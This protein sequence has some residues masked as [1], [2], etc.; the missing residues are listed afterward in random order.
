MPSPRPGAPCVLL[1]LA[2]VAACQ[3]G[4][5]P[6]VE[7]AP[8]P[9]PRAEPVHAAIAALEAGDLARARAT[10]DALIRT[11][12]LA[13]ARA[14]LAGAP[15]EALV[16]IDECLALAPDDVELQ[17]LKADASLRLAET[18]I[19][20]G[21]GH[22]GLIEG[23]LL[24]AFE[25]YTR[26]GRSPHALFGASRAAF[27]QGR[28]DEAIALARAGFDAAGRTELELGDLARRPE[29]I[30]AEE[31]LVAEAAARAEGRAEADELRREAEDALMRLLGRVSDDPWTWTWLASLQEGDGRLADAR[32]SLE[33]GLKR[34]PE[35]AGMLGQLARVTATL[36]GPGEAV[37]ALEAFAAAHPTL[38][39]AR[40]QLSVAR[41]EAEL[42]RYQETQR[43]LAPDAF[44][45]LE[46]E[47]RVLRTET[48]E[49]TSSAYGYEAVCRL[50]RGWCAFHAGELE[51]AHDEFLAMNA[52]FERAIE[53][54][55]PG[56]MESGIQGLF[57]VADTYF[58]REDLEAA[59]AI[60]ERLHELQPEDVSWANNAGF[61]LRDAADVLATEARELCAVA[62][63]IETH[64]E[65]LAER[66]AKI[67]LRAAPG[68][69][70]ERAEFR[71]AADERATRALALME[72][73]F[74]AYEAAAALAPEDV[75]IVNDA[76]LVLVYYLHRDLERAERWL[77][78]CVE[79][80]GPQLEA[81][82]AALAVEAVPERA[83]QLESE[84][85]LLQEAWA[86]AHQNL[87]VLFWLHHRDGPSAGAWL[88]KAVAIDPE[89]QSRIAVRNMLLPQT[90]GE[91]P[92]EPGDDWDLLGWG[93]PCP[94]P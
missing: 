16:S 66:R 87:G 74:S 53:W 86:D 17:L 63:G 9:E 21:G 61:N 33:L 82:R 70:E 18:K 11:R 1:P 91:V 52:L 22:A 67:G 44:A 3:G 38:P 73:S 93:R 36:A 19:A 55:Y 23:S 90:R 26:A 76:A 43:V 6:A 92:P 75:R 25:Y 83:A 2:L 30:L 35:D 89:R 34:V 68:S 80:G 58:V 32:R 46:D 27:L 37:R 4:P 5:A 71:A 10:L 40:W 88:E 78:R 77:L 12:Q 69:N 54:A 65:L 72:R 81:K 20:S 28:T 13:E 49:Y 15:D 94:E 64:P 85:D 59:G 8:V 56:V 29:R 7:P 41:F 57:F 42:A 79:L 14:K 48:P 51:R 62:R 45:R 50:A 84:L 39:A 31:L 47:F 24:D 60:Y